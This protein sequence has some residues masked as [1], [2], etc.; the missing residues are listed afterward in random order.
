MKA[1]PTLASVRKTQSRSLGYL[2]LRCAQVWSDRALERVNTEAAER[3]LTM[4]PMREAHTRLLPHLGAPEGIRITELAR[5]VGVTKQ[6]VQPLVAELAEAGVV[7]VVTDPEDARARRVFL[8]DFG[9]GAL[10]HGTGV[11]LAIEAELGLG[12]ADVR[13]LK[14]LLPKLLA[15]LEAD[16]SARTPRAAAPRPSGRRSASPSRRR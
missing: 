5:R 3:G 9:V 15:A 11:L 14:S 2:L 8:T 7:R 6:A 16:V 12:A 10:A 4:P 1:P 13:A